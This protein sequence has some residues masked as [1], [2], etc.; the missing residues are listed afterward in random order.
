M[1]GV[2]WEPEF[3]YAA[4]MEALEDRSITAL[5]V[6]MTALPWAHTRRRRLS[7]S[8]IPEDISIMSFDDEQLAEYL[9]PQVTTMRLPYLE[10][11]KAGMDL[12]SPGH[13]AGWR[14]GAW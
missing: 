5:L 10:M 7:K 14:C 4:A 13:R 3:G 9:R 6:P 8:S 1:P 12:L 2:E 11:G